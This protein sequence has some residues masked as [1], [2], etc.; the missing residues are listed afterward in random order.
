MKVLQAQNLKPLLNVLLIIILALAG[1]VIKTLPS[2]ESPSILVSVA[3]PGEN[4]N[5]LVDFAMRTLERAIKDVPNMRY[6]AFTSSSNEVTVLFQRATD[7]NMAYSFVQKQIH[8]VKN[9]NSLPADREWITVRKPVKSKLIYVTIRST[10]KD[11]DGTFLY[12]YS[13]VNVVPEIKQVPGIASGTILGKRQSTIRFT[14]DLE[15][16]R[17]WNISTH[18]VLNAVM[19]ASAL[20]WPKETGRTSNMIEY[21]LPSVSRYDT[22]ENYEG[23]ILKAFP[24]GTIL[25]LKDIAKVTRVPLYPRYYDVD[26]NIDNYPPAIIILTLHSGIDSAVLIKVLKKKCEEMKEGL[27]P[28]GIKYEISDEFPT[29]WNPPRENNE[30]K[31]L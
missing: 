7:A 10:R 20:R 17:A 19:D 31:D 14:L 15:R 4:S 24:D 25:R 9:T 29:S 6:L 1:V 23:L 5:V 26:A 12:D 2:V 11:H 28:P 30:L 8:I 13:R 18:Y 27:F 3:F 16:M 21:T 22:P